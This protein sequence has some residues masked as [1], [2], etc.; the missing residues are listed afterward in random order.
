M[1]QQDLPCLVYIGIYQ[2]RAASFLKVSCAMLF[3]TQFYSPI[4]EAWNL[5]PALNEILFA[6]IEKKKNKNEP[7]WLIK[8]PK[9]KFNL[10]H[11]PFFLQD[12]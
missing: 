8:S 1:Y 2:W 3:N 10:Y 9:C 7:V 5:S 12:M 11:A 6:E 4:P